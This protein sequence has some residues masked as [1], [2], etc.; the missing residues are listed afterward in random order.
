MAAGHM[1][2]P[3][4]NT[5]VLGNLCE[6]RNKYSATESIG[7]SPMEGFPGMISVKFYLEVNRWPTYQTS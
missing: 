1:L 7:V 3:M 4:H 5:F 2:Q 6:Y